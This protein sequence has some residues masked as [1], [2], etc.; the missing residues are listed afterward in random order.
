MSKHIASVKVPG[1]CGELVQG[2]LEG[3]HFHVT[4]PVDIYS[5]AKVEVASLTCYDNSSHS[6]YFPADRP[7][8]AEAVNKTIRFLGYSDLKLGLELHSHLPLAK[9]MA[10]STADVAASIEA[11]SL[12][13]GKELDKKDVARI[14]LSVEPTDGCFFPGIVLFDHREGKLY[15]SLGNPPPLDILVLDFGGE[16]DT[17]AFNSV[18]R[19]SLLHS[20]EPEF[21]EALEMVR[22]G[23]ES[24]DTRLIGEAAT[25]SA[26]THQ[27]ILFKPQLDK[28]IA[29][30]REVGAVGINVAHSGTVIGILLDGKEQDQEAK[31]IRQ[32][33]VTCFLQKHLPDLEKIVSCSVIS[34]GSIIYNS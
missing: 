17:L 8:S 19:K 13:L 9:G 26:R 4:C 25:L 10:S 20:L 28:L 12:A 15:E 27:A 5:E 31:H 29:L 2:T 33:E 16:V 32:K 14:A 30:S 24:G 18:D 3:I 23:L 7:K 6:F 34:G 22:K 21:K 1:T 11:T